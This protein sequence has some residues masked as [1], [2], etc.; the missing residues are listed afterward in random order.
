MAAALSAQGLL[1]QYAVAA[2]WFA[3]L[4]LRASQRTGPYK[5]IPDATG[6]QDEKVDLV[7]HLDL[8]D[9]GLTNNALDLLAAVIVDVPERTGDG[10]VISDVA[11]VHLNPEG[12][13]PFGFSCILFLR[14]VFGDCMSFGATKLM[15]SPRTMR[16]KR[17]QLKPNGFGPSGFR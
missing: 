8:E 13:K 7:I 4:S 16:Q 14:M 1:S 15:Q 12:S 10:H 3:A 17:M 6:R 11:A 2:Q 5:R 9:V